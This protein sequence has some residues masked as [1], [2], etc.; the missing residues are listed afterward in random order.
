[1]WGP[2]R[3][4]DPR[5][6]LLSDAGIDL[7]P[8]SQ[9]G[10]GV[11][12]SVV[13]YNVTVANLD[14]QP[15]GYTLLAEDDTWPSVP[16]PW[17]TTIIPEQTPVLNPG[18]SI[19]VV[20]QVQLP[21]TPGPEDTILVSARSDLD[22]GTRQYAAVATGFVLATVH[23]DK[24]KMNWKPANGGIYKLVGLVRVLEQDRAPVA[25]ATASAEWTLPDGLTI[26]GTAVTA[27][28]GAARFQ[29][30]S[31]LPGLYSLT[32]LGVQAA[33]YAYDPAQNRETSKELRIGK[34]AVQWSQ[35]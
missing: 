9:S 32:V 28:N 2:E 3:P 34:Q 19:N 21:G 13:S 26:E 6:A 30:R 12:G 20:V 15:T 25:G 4:A 5:I 1:V 14:T 31:G 7:S 22:G 18:E 16:T 23:V 27:A 29:L 17:P 11:P 35:R 8:A 24:I 10:Q 33:G